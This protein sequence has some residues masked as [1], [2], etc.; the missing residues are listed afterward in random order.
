MDTTVGEQSPIRL[1]GNDAVHGD[2]HPGNV[3][4]RGG[5]VTGVVDWDAASRGDRRFDL[6]TLRFGLHAKSTDA[7]VVVA[8]DRVLDDLPGEILRPRWAHMSLRMVGWA[9]RH[10]TPPEIDHWLD[11]AE[12]RAWV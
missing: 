9:I 7:D 6:I 12:E 1:T 5:A 10:F 4:A 3:L 8:M 11:L 2:F